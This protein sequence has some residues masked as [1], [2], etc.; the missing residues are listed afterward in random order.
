MD[1]QRIRGLVAKSDDSTVE[2]KLRKALAG[3]LSSQ[4]TSMKSVFINGYKFDI[5]DRERCRK[6]QNSRIMVE[7]DNQEFYGKLKAIYE[8]DYYG[9][10]KVVMFRCDWVDI[11]KGLWKYGNGGVV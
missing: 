2:G 9:S 10:Y 7:A 11:H 3:G 8:L 4:A 1:Y 6:T 5:V